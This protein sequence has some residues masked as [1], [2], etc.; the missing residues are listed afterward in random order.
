MIAMTLFSPT[1]W[2]DRVTSGIILGAGLALLI[3]QVACPRPLQVAAVCTGE[4]T[5]T[6]W[7]VVLS[8]ASI[9]IT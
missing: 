9:T 8:T 2:F 4:S 3:S 5:M 6:A 7:E 1:L